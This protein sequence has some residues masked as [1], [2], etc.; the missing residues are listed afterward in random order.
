MKSAT[1]TYLF[2]A[3]LLTGS[4]GFAQTNN[5]SIENNQMEATLTANKE[6]IRSLYENVMNNRKFDLLNLIVSEDYVNAQGEKGGEAFKKGIMAVITAFPDARWTLTEMIAE[7]N[8]V[9][10]KQCVEGT[11]K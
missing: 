2:L 6:T 1:K 11:H 5:H 3:A 7:G 4:F 10:V 9:F 8:K